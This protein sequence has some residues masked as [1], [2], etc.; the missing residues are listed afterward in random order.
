MPNVHI[1]GELAKLSIYIDRE[2]Y[3]ASVPDEFARGL[4]EFPE[5]IYNSV[6]LSLYG[7]EDIRKLTTTQKDDFVLV[8]R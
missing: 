6:A 2:I 4:R 3:H 5:A 1:Y 8:F 7:V